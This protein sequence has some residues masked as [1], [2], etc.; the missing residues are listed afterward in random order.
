MNNFRVQHM[1]RTIPKREG[2]VPLGPSETGAPIPIELRQVF[3]ERTSQERTWFNAGTCFFR[4]GEF[5]SDGFAQLLEP[6]STFLLGARKRTF[7]SNSS[8]LIFLGDLR[9]RPA[10]LRPRNNRSYAGER[11]STGVY[12]NYTLFCLREPLLCYNVCADPTSA[13]ERGD[14]L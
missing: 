6:L 1:V 12:C 7:L 11:W 10:S 4:H 5:I 14:G 8:N 3:L 9:R 13:G 2:L